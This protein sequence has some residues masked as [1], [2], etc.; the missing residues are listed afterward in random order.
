MGRGLRRPERTSKYRMHW[1]ELGYSALIPA[2]ALLLGGALQEAAVL[3]CALSVVIWVIGHRQVQQGWNA[4]STIFL[5]LALWSLF[6][7]LPLPL[8][9]IGKISPSTA[10]IWSRSVHSFGS[11][12]PGWVTLS[13]DRS[14]TWLEVAKWTTYAAA[15]AVS[16][17]ATRLRGH[18]QYAL[19]TIGTTAVLVSGATIA[20]A[21]VSA[22]TV[23]GI[24]VPRG[25]AEH[26]LVG[27]L[28]NPNNLAGLANLGTFCTLALIGAR[29]GRLPT[30]P[31]VA[32]GLTCIGATVLSGSRG[33]MVTL[34]LGLLAAGAFWESR[35]PQSHFRRSLR[36]VAH[37]ALSS[38]CAVVIL[39][40]GAST[41]LEKV[42]FDADVEK[43]RSLGKLVP[44][45]RDHGVVGIGRGAFETISDRYLEPGPNIV[46]QKVENFP[47]LWAIEWGIP[48][49]VTA[50]VS[51][52]WLLRPARLPWSKSRSVRLIW[53]ALASLVIQ[54][55]VDLGI[56]LVSLGLCASFLVGAL[57]GSRPASESHRLVGERHRRYR[58]TFA[59]GG[60]LLGGWSTA[61]A[62]RAGPGLM[63]VRDAVHG[64]L[65]AE[66]RDNSS[67]EAFSGRLREEMLKRP[68]E[69]YFAVAGII[70]AIRAQRDAL[71]W[72]AAALERSPSSGR[73]HYLTALALHQRGY[74]KQALME[75]KLAIGFD[76]RLTR[77]AVRQA[78]EWTS[79]IVTLER[80][81]PE[82]DKGNQALLTL[83]EYLP[84]DFPD[85][86]IRLLNNALDRDPQSVRVHV[87]MAL[88]LLAELREQ[89]R[90]CETNPGDQVCSAAWRDAKLT[91]VG[92][93]IENV[94][95]LDGRS[96]EVVR[97]KMQFLEAKGLPSARVAELADDCT[98]CSGAASCYRE[99]LSLLRG[100]ADSNRLK[101]LEDR[102]LSVACVDEEACI[103][104]E[105]WIAGEA[106]R[107]GAWARAAMLRTRVAGRTHTGDAW[108]EVAKAAIRAQG[109]EQAKTA[110][111]RATVLGAD[112]TEVKAE[113]QDAR[114]APFSER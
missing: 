23:F 1:A 21:L 104:A 70:A 29:R 71:P 49:A 65:E 46:V 108:L 114:R 36:T 92:K 106:A 94:E 109:W 35:P 27:P 75:F 54:N 17:T 89:K 41:P 74:L 38:A 52:A 80:I 13:L 76:P 47:L 30:A 50:L 11:D 72:A 73:V 62:F 5:G 32:I 83:A 93:H 56:E 67:Y 113:L 24:Y 16:V 12:P 25:L 34:I 103:L 28:V 57:E 7:V 66:V 55:L 111:D 48:I 91:S 100:Q 53:I 68:A 58:M 45:L 43:L 8:T 37:I 60:L 69:P 112:A 85:P 3:I 97:I 64:E 77:V 15:V 78:M 105:S 110:I 107:R 61:A 86:R 42:L 84:G 6:S 40:L 59:Y 44:I 87:A 4:I 10:E 102:Y 79:D 51:L 90:L 95:H 20:H 14:A 31:L 98:N 39:L 9:L 26:V 19:I 99:A 96:C 33:G 22:Q 88:I 81:V 101:S 63:E 18:C 82:G 2:S